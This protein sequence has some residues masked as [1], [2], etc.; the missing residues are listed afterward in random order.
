MAQD[1]VFE[2]RNY[3]LHPGRRDELI[4]LFERE[5][6]ESQEALGTNVVATFRNADDPDRF[7]WLRSFRDFRARLAACDA[8]YAGPVWQAHRNAANATMIDSDNVL[9]LKPV[10]GDLARNPATRAPV[11]AE[12]LPNSLFV[13][14]TYFLA[15][16]AARDFAV[17]FAREIAPRA[18]GELLAT[19]ATDHTPNNYPGLPVRENET[20]FVAL[21]R[22]AHASAYAPL[23][24]SAWPH[25]AAPT[26]TLRLK[27]TARSLLR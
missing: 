21:T 8:F 14:T 5:F 20:V 11:A 25:F 16:H 2:L 17:F 3:T 4:A 19:F 9:L 1:R 18:P 12:A 15:P 23:P 24:A 10:S 7:V 27:P 26:E 22:F 6:V 13:A